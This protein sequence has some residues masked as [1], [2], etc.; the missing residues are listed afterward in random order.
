VDSLAIAQE[1]SDGFLNVWVKM[2]RIDDLDIWTTA[3]MGEGS[4]DTLK[5]RAKIFAAVPSYQD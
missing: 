3:E 4:A 1:S 2:N 5:S